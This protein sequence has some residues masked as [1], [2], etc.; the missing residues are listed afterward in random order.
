VSFGMVLLIACA[1]LANFF[2]ARATARRKE[3]AV[4]RALGASRGRLMWQVLTEGVLIGLAAGGITLIASPLLCDFI[5]REIQSR[6]VF[7]SQIS[8]FLPFDFHLTVGY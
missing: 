1:N 6:I 8:T 3:M 2:L 5:W 7:R 4:R